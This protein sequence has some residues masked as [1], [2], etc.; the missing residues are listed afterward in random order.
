MEHTKSEKELKSHTRHE[1]ISETKEQV[2]L[3]PSI[4]SKDST[5]EDNYKEEENPKETLNQS[6][7]TLTNKNDLS[8]ES[9]QDKELPKQELKEKSV[10]ETSKEQETNETNERLIVEI[11]IEELLDKNPFRSIKSM[12]FN[13]SLIVMSMSAVI[14]FYSL[15]Y[16]FCDWI[17]NKSLYLSRDEN[18]ILFTHSVITILIQLVLRWDIHY[19]S[20]GLEKNTNLIFHFRTFMVLLLLEFVF[21]TR[22]VFVFY[23]IRGEIFLRISSILF[24]IFFK[25]SFKVFLL[26]LS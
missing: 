20:V 24:F 17:L 23:P 11:T 16:L 14:I 7:L 5:D 19:C 18:W 8:E 13:I 12:A 21:I 26:I 3:S 22:T 10:K 2:T 6:I 4:R 15:W 25:I 9:K 1:I